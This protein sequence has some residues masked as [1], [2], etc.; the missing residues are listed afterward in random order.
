MI[1]TV[2]FLLVFFMIA[3]LAMT[4]QTGLPV[5]L[6]RAS[7]GER[8]ARASVTVTITSDNDL[9]VDKQPVTLGTLGR[10]LKSKI[11]ENPK[12][13]VIINADKR[14]R[15]GQV[16]AVMDEAKKYASHMAIAT[17]PLPQGEGAR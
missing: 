4:A 15:H 5:N 16:I 11:Q 9:Y 2:F 10:V 14:V 1:D 3:S 8:E 13:Y 12:A 17:E 6:P 7:A